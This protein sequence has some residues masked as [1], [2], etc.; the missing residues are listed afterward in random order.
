VLV[1][2]VG[3]VRLRLDGF[4][5]ISDAD[6]ETSLQ[7]NLFAA[8]RATRAAVAAMFPRGGGA[9]VSVVSVNAFSSPT[10]W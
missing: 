2:N 1:T 6:L 9:I 3:G 5:E 10:G 4:L 7:L 8:L